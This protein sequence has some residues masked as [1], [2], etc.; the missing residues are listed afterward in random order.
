MKDKCTTDQLINWMKG[1][2]VS[3]ITWICPQWKLKYATIELY[4]H[5]IPILG[6]HYSTV[7]SPSRLCRQHGRPQ[8]I[9]TVLPN[10]EDFSLRQDFLD[11]VKTLWPRRSLE[12]NMHLTIYVTTDDNYKAWVAMQASEPPR[13]SKYKRTQMLLNKSQKKKQKHN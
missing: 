10:F 13:L 6:L 1:V 8:F 11:K 4:D 3:E 2:A 12:R 5:Y 7:I 9:L